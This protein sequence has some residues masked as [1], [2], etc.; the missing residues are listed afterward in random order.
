MNIKK[1]FIMT[2]ILLIIYVLIQ[3][4]FKDLN[5]GHEIKYEIKQ[6]KDCEKRLRN[7]RRGTCTLLRRNMEICAFTGQQKSA[8]PEKPDT[9]RQKCGST[10]RLSGPAGRG[11]GAS[12]AP[13]CQGR[14]RRKGDDQHR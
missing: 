14:H 4:S 10:G 2:F 3:M 5:H 7:G 8:A 12:G 6:K 9:A 11:E 1:L 13:A